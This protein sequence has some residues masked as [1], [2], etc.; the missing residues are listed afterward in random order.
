MGTALCLSG[1]VGQFLLCSI[2]QTDQSFSEIDLFIKVP[3]LFPE[4][5]EEVQTNAVATFRPS[6]SGVPMSG[7]ELMQGA[8]RG[9]AV[10]VSAAP[11]GVLFGA[12][13]VEKAC[14]SAMR[15]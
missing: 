4:A 6:R 8:R 7:S 3:A 12:V 14:R 15:F 11:F 5:S 13:A 2:S 1:D 9:I 10:A